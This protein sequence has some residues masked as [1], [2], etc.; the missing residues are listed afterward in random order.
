MIID[1]IDKVAESQFNLCDVP[2][3]VIVQSSGKESLV[4]G[5]IEPVVLSWVMLVI[6]PMEQ[7][8]NL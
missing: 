3:L 4:R 1:I 7:A 5:Q 6:I 8:G 2:Q